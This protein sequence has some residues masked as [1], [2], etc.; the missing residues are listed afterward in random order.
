MIEL[1]EIFDVKYGNSFDLNKL[2]Q[3]INGIN[4]VSRTAKNNGISAKV[5]EIIGAE[6]MPKGSITVSLGG[7]VLEAF[8]QPD[9]YYTGYHIY[10]LTTKNDI[11][12]TDAQKLFYCACIRSNKYKYS[13]GRQ[14][15]RTLKSLLVPSIDEIP[16]W[17][18][19][20]NLIRFE[21]ID[22][23]VNDE[24]ID[25]NTNNWKSFRYDEL[26]EIE[27]G[28]GDRRKDL[29]DNGTT[30]FITSS[31]ANNGL[32]GF[33]KAKPIHKKNTIGVNRNG[34]VAE[35][36]YQPVAFCSTED[37]HIFVPKFELNQYIAMF[38]I[39]LIKKEKYRY[40]Y[41]RK[42]GIERMNKSTI[43]L[44]VNS[45]G[46]PDWKFMERY[47]KSLPFSSKI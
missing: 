8:V 41:G 19:E 31:D 42:W 9:E 6:K 18:N 29:G 21:G 46:Q 35:A 15:N 4:F 22:K 40:S 7:S 33:T 23:A 28:R 26:F 20:V 37:V 1:Q 2:N 39:A 13:Y 17:V 34:S 14:A 5:T 27:R 16:D 11:E 3:S 47:I 36:F 25:L 12:L 30:P 38:L 45:E 32:T 10:C 44:P 43:N 24:N